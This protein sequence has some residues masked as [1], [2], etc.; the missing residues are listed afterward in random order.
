[1]LLLAQYYSVS[2]KHRQ[3]HSVRTLPYVGRDAMWQKG[4]V[5]RVNIH[6]VVELTSVNTRTHTTHT[7][8][9]AKKIR[10]SS[11]TER[12]S[13]ICQVYFIDSVV[14]PGDIHYYKDNIKTKQQTDWCSRPRHCCQDSLCSHH[15][16]SS[17]TD[18]KVKY[19]NQELIYTSRLN[20]QTVPNHCML[21]VDL[22]WLLDIYIMQS[23]LLLFLTRDK[24]PGV[25]KIQEI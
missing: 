12:L 24:V 14:N 20:T 4:P 16:G 3:C 23:S 5:N 1:V 2:Q 11:Y 21:A 17:M 25:P 22:T 19:M 8:G 7:A 10:R 18:T 9:L 13:S 6:N 15:S